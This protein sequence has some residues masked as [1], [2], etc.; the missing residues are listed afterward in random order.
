MRLT[1]FGLAAV[2]SL[3]LITSLGVVACGGD[4]EATPDPATQGQDPTANDPFGRTTGGGNTNDSGGGGGGGGGGE[5]DGGALDPD[6]GTTDPDSGEVI[7]PPGTCGTA[8]PPTGFI[9][10]VSV[11]VAAANRTYAL[12]VPAGYDGTRKLPLVFGFHGDGGN[13]AAYR[14]S[15]PIEAQAGGRA[16]FVWPNGTNNNAG[17]SFDQGRN[18]PQ[19]ADVTFFEAMITQLSARYCVDTTRVYAHGM[20]GGAY[21]VN[22][23]GRWKNTALRAIAPMSGGGPFGIG[24]GDFD[25]QTGNLKVTGPLAAFIVHGQSDGSVN[26]TEAQKSLTYWRAAAKS[27]AGQAATNPS[28]C[29]RQNGGLKPVVYCAIPGLGHTIWTGAAAGVWSFFSAN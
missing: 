14:N 26:I 27:T 6:G 1:S 5:T 28:P 4:G 3:G 25:P 21:F 18:P 11:T 8:N 13:G 20:S 2:L 12:S 7:V 15:F 16:I 19:N 24:S 23:L 29:Q 22:Q 17:R 9:A 10:S